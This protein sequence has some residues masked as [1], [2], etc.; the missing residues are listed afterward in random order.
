MTNNFHTKLNGGIVTPYTIA[1]GLAVVLI[2]INVK[3]H[4]L[5]GATKIQNICLS[6]LRDF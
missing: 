1:E 3:G 2:A 5:Y 4:E 6:A